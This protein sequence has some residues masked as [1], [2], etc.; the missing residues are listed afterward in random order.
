M[1]AEKQKSGVS[2][3]VYSHTS[4]NNSVHGSNPKKFIPSSSGLASFL[5]AMSKVSKNFLI[6]VKKSQN[7]LLNSLGNT[8]LKLLSPNSELDCDPVKTGIDSKLK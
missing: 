6:E 3:P 8:F 7:N 2:V 4:I 5:E 1:S